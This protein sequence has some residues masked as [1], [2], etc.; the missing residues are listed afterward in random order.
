MVL[1]TLA[2]IAM[3][4]GILLAANGLY[5]TVCRL[6]NRGG[7]RL[8]V[9]AEFTSL[10]ADETRIVAEGPATAATTLFEHFVVR[11]NG[12][13]IEMVV[14]SIDFGQRGAHWQ[15]QDVESLRASRWVSP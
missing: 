3:T 13:S 6:R 5:V 4:V 7:R 15:A 2:A 1:L 10:W 8:P 9:V 11:A 14:M 12:R